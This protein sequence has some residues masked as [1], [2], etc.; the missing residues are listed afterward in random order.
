MRTLNDAQK[1]VIRW[2]DRE[3]IGAVCFEGGYKFPEAFRCDAALARRFLEAGMAGPFEA[4]I[5]R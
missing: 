3:R 4:E 1:A 5:L 2:M